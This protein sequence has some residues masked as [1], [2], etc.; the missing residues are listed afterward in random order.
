M[1]HICVLSCSVM[2][3]FLWP[4]WTLASQVPL[5]MGFFRQ[6]YWS[7]LLWPPP[8]NLPDKGIESMSLMSPA[9][10]GGFFNWIQLLIWETIWTIIGNIKWETIW[11]ISVLLQGSWN[12]NKRIDSFFFCIL[13]NQK[14][15]SIKKLVGKHTF[16]PPW[17]LSPENCFN[18]FVIMVHM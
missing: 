17:I 18:F 5:S 1:K 16:F 11:T 2:P 13:K 9:L 3:D 12:R 4:Q 14:Q 6:E 10:A 8:G 15:N 7:G